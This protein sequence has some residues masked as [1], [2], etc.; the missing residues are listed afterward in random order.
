[1]GALCILGP[2]LFLLLATPHPAA[3]FPQGGEQTVLPAG[4]DFAEEALR[5]PREVFKSEQQG[6]VKSYL[7]NLGDLAFNSPTILGGAARTAG[8][9][10]GTCHVDG[11]ANARL[12]VPGMSTRR[13]N[14]DTTGPLFNPRADNHVLDPVRIPSLRG[15]R[16]LAPYGHDGRI[17]SLRDFVHNVIVGEF[18]GPE[19]APAI[20]DA[21]V[22]YIQDI[23]FLPNP[24]LGAAGKLVAPASEAEQRGEI[25][26]NRPFR[27]D[28]KVSCAACHVPSAAFLDHAQHDVGS[29][30]IYRTPTL[31]NA[32][33][34]APYFHDG[35]YD[36]FDQVIDHFDRAFDLG[37]TPA[38]R[39]D[40]V[41]YLTAVGN[42]VLPYETDG[43]GAQ[44][45][46]IDDFVSVL[47]TAIP[48]HDAAVVQLAVA[49][50]GRE[51]RELTEQFPDL[52]DGVVTGGT[53]ERRIARKALKELVLILRRIDLAA[54][55]GRFDE[56]AAERAAYRKLAFAAVPLALRTA[57]PWS[58]FNPQLRRAHFAALR[59]LL[60]TAHKLPQ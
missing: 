41:A 47:D 24:R 31:R 7:V 29:G 40:L 30:G 8:M 42:G 36:T 19:P 56:A 44:L 17:G 4:T 46:E 33:F 26:F 22:A 20:L 39:A 16:Y 9:S 53:D 25:L 11:A 54:A 27:H 3:A 49:T 51:L 57:E 45:K 14:F 58:L 34:N 43:I 60:V 5:R 1:L 15:A 59:T 23:D 52:R 55:A 28:P 21:L 48:A 18:A 50:V 32:D 2:I 35:R 38:D 6:G 12:F 37:L 10:C 13:G